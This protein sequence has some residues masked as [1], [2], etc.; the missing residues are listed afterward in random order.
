MKAKRIENKEC[1]ENGM[2][3]SQSGDGTVCDVPRCVGPE[4]SDLEGESTCGQN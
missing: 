3:S 4:Q 1:I 2:Y